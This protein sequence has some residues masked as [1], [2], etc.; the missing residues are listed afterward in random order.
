MFFNFSFVCLFLLL[1]FSFYCFEPVVYILR[2][3]FVVDLA[4][5]FLLS[6]VFALRVTCIHM[7]IRSVLSTSE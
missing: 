3:D 7:T 1:F 5:P 6:A 4:S 2:S